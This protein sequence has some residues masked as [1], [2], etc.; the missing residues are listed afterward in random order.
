MAAK[1]SKSERV[2]LN[3][4]QELGEENLASYEVKFQ[5][6]RDHYLPSA[7]PGTALLLARAVEVI[8]LSSG[9]WKSLYINQPRRTIAI[10]SNQVAIDRMYLKHVLGK[11]DIMVFKLGKY[12]IDPIS[13]DMISEEFR[14]IRL[15]D[16]LALK[17]LDCDMRLYIC[18]FKESLI[19]IHFE[20]DVDV[21]DW[22]VWMMDNGDPESFRKIYTIK[23]DIR[24]DDSIVS[25]FG[26]RK[27]VEKEGF[28]LFVYNPNSEHIDYI[29]ISA[30]RS[31]FVVKAYTETLLLL[32]T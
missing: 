24:D 30:K 17:L 2:E 32:D 20:F 29:G 15:P 10:H 22:D 7:E 3:W 25:V 9:T 16:N 19:V 6:I 12:G 31:S 27:S 1:H 18:K 23:S 8:R 26:S 28:E 11:Y 14:E 21:T 13:F 5:K 4:E